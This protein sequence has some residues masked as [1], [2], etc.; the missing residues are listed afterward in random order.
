MTPAA[1][2]ARAEALG[3]T[4]LPDGPHIRVRGHREAV[5][6]VAP[7]LS[8]NKPAIL[9]ILA[10]GAATNADRQDDLDSLIRGAATYY[11]ATPDDME[12]MAQLAQRDPAG[13]R[14][15]LLAD[16]LRPFYRRA[17]A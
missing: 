13:L 4:L 3:L 16:P 7:L 5:A 9:A 10:G 2:L 15:A 14:R 1:I 6:E 12:I 11:A 8:A 17:S